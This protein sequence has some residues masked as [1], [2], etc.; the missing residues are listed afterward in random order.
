MLQTGCS[1]GAKAILIKRH[2]SLFIK[3][4]VIKDLYYI[5][6]R[7]LKLFRISR[8]G[9]KGKV[10]ELYIF[11]PRFSLREIYLSQQH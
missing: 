9:R 4:I 2:Y 11:A 10:V 1:D 6:C 7:L 5:Q 8:Q 3:L